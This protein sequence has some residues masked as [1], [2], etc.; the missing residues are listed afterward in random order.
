MEFTDVF[1][2]EPDMWSFLPMPI[3]SIIFLYEIKDE[4]KEVI[5]AAQKTE[6]QDALLKEEN[7]FFVKQNISNACGT[8]ALLH[9]LC[10]TVENVGGAKEGSI[11]RDFMEKTKSSEYSDQQGDVRAKYINESDEVETVHMKYAVEGN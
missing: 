9:S 2:L 10:N 11:L 6:D 7:P 8:I 1:S 3:S 5:Y 4:H